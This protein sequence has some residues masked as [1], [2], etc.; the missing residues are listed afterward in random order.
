MI[1]STL[2]LDHIQVLD[3]GKQVVGFPGSTLNKLERLLK[4]YG[5]EPHSVIGSSCIGASV[6]GGICNNSGGALVKR[7]PAYTEMALYAKL[8]ADGQ[9]RLVNHLGINLGDT[10]EEILTRLEKGDYRPTM[11]NMASCALRTT[12]TPAGCAM[13][14]PI[15]LPALT[16][17]NAA[18]L[19]LPAVPVSWR[20]L[21]YVWTPLPKKIKSRCSI[22]APTTP[23]Y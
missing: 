23:Q 1:V 4:P 22:S 15:P 6:I 19:K 11:L 14:M 9:L 12:N 3:N 20:C 7:G 8:D 21:R 5:R 18:C 10:P 17:I 13:S 2:R 16:P